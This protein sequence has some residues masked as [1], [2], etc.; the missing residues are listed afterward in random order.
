VLQI[1][2]FNVADVEFRCLQT[3]DVGFCV[4]E[5]GKAPDV[6]CCMQHGRNIVATW[7]QHEGGGDLLMFECCTQPS[8]NGSQHARNFC[9]LTLK[10]TA[11]V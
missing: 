5:G 1:L 11:E 6:G 9:S 3:C 7:S 8:R 2:N 4:E 10:R